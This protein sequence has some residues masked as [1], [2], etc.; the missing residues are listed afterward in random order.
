M[1]KI[2]WMGNFRI[3][4]Q[5]N[6]YDKAKNTLGPAT[7]KIPTYRSIAHIPLSGLRQ[8]Y[9]TYKQNEA[10]VL[11]IKSIWVLFSELGEGSAQ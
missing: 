7:A 10:P 6:G 4:G 8:L 11:S 1:N 9:F 3:L 5:N 2:I